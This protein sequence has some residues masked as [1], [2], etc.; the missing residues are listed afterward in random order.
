MLYT[1]QRSASDATVGTDI[2]SNETWRIA[3]DSRVLSRIGL[4]G[5][6]APGDTKVELFAGNLRIGEFY[7]SAMGAPQAL[8]DMFDVNVII[9]GGMPLVANVSD[10]PAT[11]P[12][13]LVVEI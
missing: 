9:P 12:I 3:S 1:V 11:N 10:A 8:R 7:N 4:T 2:I 5:S 6:A 13:Y